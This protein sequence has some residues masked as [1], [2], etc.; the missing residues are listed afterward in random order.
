M[1]RALPSSCSIKQLGVLVLSTA[2]P[3][4]WDASPLQ[5]YPQQYVAGTYFIHLCE[6]RQCG[7]KETT[8]YRD[9]CSLKH[10]PYNDRNLYSTLSNATENKWIYWRQF[11]TKS[12][13][14]KSWNK[15]PWHLFEAVWIVQGIKNQWV[16]W[17]LSGVSASLIKNNWLQNTA[18][19]S[20]FQFITEHSIECFEICQ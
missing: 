4:G 19:S 16:K 9:K 2:S 5:G 10:Q 12:Q 17:W 1:A 15:R 3:P 7:A 20:L 6:Q 13:K 18:L 11:I 14:C 8:H